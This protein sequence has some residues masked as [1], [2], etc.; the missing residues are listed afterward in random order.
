MSLLTFTLI[1]GLVNCSDYYYATYDFRDD[2]D[3][4][5]I[6]NSDAENNIG[7]VDLA[8]EVSINE[9][10]SILKE[11]K[12]HKKVFRMSNINGALYTPLIWNYFDNQ[13]LGTIEFWIYILSIN[14]RYFIFSIGN[15][16][17]KLR[18]D[19]NSYIYTEGDSTTIPYSLDTWNHIR[20]DFNC[21]EYNYDFYLNDIFKGNMIFDIN[22]TTLNQIYL[23]AGGNQSIV[24]IDAI[25]YS[26]DFNY[27][28]G[29]NKFPELNMTDILTPIFSL[30]FLIFLM[31]IMIFIYMKVRI[32]LVILVLFLFSL[33]IGIYSLSLEYIPF[34]PYFSIFFMLFQSVIFLKRSLEVYR[35]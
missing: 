13:I 22:D 32:W 2:L 6:T 9:T 19:E 29:D 23:W 16:R 35:L 1:I 7:F 8:S 33:I 18:F 21:N 11:F 27:N 20:I 3:G 5:Y 34:N 26:W 14:T 25:G 30:L 28:I 10:I 12:E 24:Y 15:N 17:I 4:V 31:I